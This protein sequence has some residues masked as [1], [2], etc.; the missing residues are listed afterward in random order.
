MKFTFGEKWKEEE[1]RENER[2]RANSPS[3]QLGG[4]APGTPGESILPCES[5]S[6]EGVFP[7]GIFPIFPTV[8][9]SFSLGPTQ[10]PS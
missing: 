3:G 10:A 2:E 7:H 6:A 5:S 9:M 1:R 8:T 4:E